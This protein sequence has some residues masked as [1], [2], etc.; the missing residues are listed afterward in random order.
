[1]CEINTAFFNFVLCVRPL[2]RKGVA[3]LEISSHFTEKNSTSL[4]IAFKLPVHFTRKYDFI[5]KC[6]YI[7]TQLYSVCLFMG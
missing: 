5:R 4:E 2:H 7:H 6:I 1:M 3:S